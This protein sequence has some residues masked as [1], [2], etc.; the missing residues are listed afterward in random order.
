[1]LPCTARGNAIGFCW[2]ALLLGCG[3]GNGSS[4]GGASG[5]AASAGNTSSGGSAG[6]GSGG[7]GSGGSTSAG[8]GSSS[9]TFQGTYLLELEEAE[10]SKVN[11]DE[12][13]VIA[14]AG[15][16][17]SEFLCTPGNPVTRCT[18]GDLLLTQDGP[19]T[20]GC[21]TLRDQIRALLQAQVQ[22]GVL[23]STAEPCGP[24]G[25]TAHPEYFATGTSSDVVQSLT[26]NF[27]TLCQSFVDCVTMPASAP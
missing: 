6:G 2:A 18:S 9:C 23:L 26:S 25:I 15:N 11:V 1:M 21:T 27:A 12:C 13:S 19:A 7:T 3:S 4:N 10:L 5:S 16:L 17:C 24:D 14:C 22:A 8:N 20:A